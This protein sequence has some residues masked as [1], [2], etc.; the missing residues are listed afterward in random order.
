MGGR[1]PGGR[2]APGDRTR[3]TGRLVRRPSLTSAFQVRKASALLRCSW[4]SRAHGLFPRHRLSEAY[5]GMGGTIGAG[6]SLHLDEVQAADE[7]PQPGE[8]VVAGVER[9]VVVD[10]VR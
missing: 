10:D 1:T 9:R 5:P 4:P 8:A 6:D 7:H 2:E 3:R